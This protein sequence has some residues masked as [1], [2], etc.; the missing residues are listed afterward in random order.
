[1]TSLT[2]SLYLSFSNSQPSRTFSPVH[3]HF[4]PTSIH[5]Q[6]LFP[7]P[8]LLLLP[9]SQSSPLPR[10]TF[11]ASSSHMPPADSLLHSALTRAALLAQPP[12][13]G[14][15]SLS[16]SDSDDDLISVRTPLASSTPTTSLSPATSR[17]SSPTRSNSTNPSPTKGGGI[18]LG[19]TKTRSGAGKPR[20]DKTKE[21]EKADQAGKTMDPLIKFPGEVSG[22]IFGELGVDDLLSV[23]LVCKKWRRSATIS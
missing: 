13:E 20:R 22:R 23:G 16:L 19:L 21:R 7:V 9:H 4:P 18:A 12:Q 2:F 6:I 11:P 14:F 5:S 8:T 17:S 1:M 3:H 10:T 15:Q